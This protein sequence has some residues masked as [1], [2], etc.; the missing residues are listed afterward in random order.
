MDDYAKEIERLERLY[1]EVQTDEEGN[2]EFDIA[3]D[4]GSEIDCC[5]E[6]SGGTDTEQSDDDEQQNDSPRGIIDTQNQS[7]DLRGQQRHLYYESKDNIK[8]KKHLPPTN[9]RTRQ[10]NIV[11]HLPGPKGNG[12]DKFTPLDCWS[13]F[14]SPNLLNMVVNN[15]NIF[16]ENIS[17][18]YKDQSDCRK[19]DVIEIK[20]LFG[21]LFL[22]GVFK[23]GRRNMKDFWATDGTGVEIFPAAMAYRR[24]KFLLR[25]LR[26]D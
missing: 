23:G 7:S 16:I 18:N 22:A 24:F 11:V 3:G 15:T 9:V 8:W 10:H 6:I 4:S 21:L 2:E 13:C 19:T 5:E 1:E 20:A 12:K 26:F 17:S 14:I 25:C